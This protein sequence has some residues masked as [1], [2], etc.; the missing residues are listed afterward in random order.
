MVKKSC[1][2]AQDKVSD[3]ELGVFLTSLSAD[4]FVRRLCIKQTFRG[5]VVEPLA[6]CV[7]AEVIK[8]RLQKIHGFGVN[9]D[10]TGSFIDIN[11][12]Y[13]SQLTPQFSYSAKP[14]D[15]VMSPVGGHIV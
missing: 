14:V 7:D 5:G 2:W 6:L 13:P 10:T 9:V 12:M 11:S 4:H 15:Y 8:T 3:P 1:E